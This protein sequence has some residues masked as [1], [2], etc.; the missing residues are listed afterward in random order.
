TPPAWPRPAPPA[1]APRDGPRPRPSVG[2]RTLEVAHEVLGVH[3][4]RDLDELPAVGPEV[5][6][7]LLRRVGEDRRREVL[8]PLDLRH[9][10]TLL[11]PTRASDRPGGGR[12]LP[13]VDVH[14]EH[15]LVR[16]T[17]LEQVV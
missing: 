15:D 2:H 14:G 9:G 16:V 17:L 4:R 1:R 7:D 11:R 3:P 12:H 8:P 6:E 10:A 5:V 13:S